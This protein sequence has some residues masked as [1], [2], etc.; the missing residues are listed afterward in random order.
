[1]NWIE[2]TWVS[3]LGTFSW[4]RSMCV[5]FLKSF[6]ITPIAF[7]KCTLF[8]NYRLHSNRDREILIDFEDL[9]RWM[10]NEGF[11]T[12]FMPSSVVGRWVN[13][14]ILLTKIW[15]TIGEKWERVKKIRNEN[16]TQITSVMKTWDEFKWHLNICFLLKIAKITAAIFYHYVVDSR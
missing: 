10:T 1:M 11:P 9:W 8:S 4:S 12:I 15:L 7:K 6:I 14:M 5:S 13:N 3:L 16:G 2:L